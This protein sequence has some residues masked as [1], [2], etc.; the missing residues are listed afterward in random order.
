M[1]HKEELPFHRYSET[2]KYVNILNG[3]PVLSIDPDFP[4]VI[5]QFSMMHN[6]AQAESPHRHDYYEIL[7]VEEGAGQ[8][9]IDYEPYDI[10]PPVFYFLSKG[11]IHFWN[12]S[13]PL[14]GK[15][16]L[17]PREFLL[18]P[19]LGF[20][21]EGDISIFNSLSKAPYVCVDGERY[22][23]LRA[24][25]QEVSE[26]YNRGMHRNLSVLRSFVHILLVNLLRIH[27]T[28]QPKDILDQPNT[29]V[30]K[31]RQLVCENFVMIR[32]VQEYADLIGISTTHLRDTVKE[33]TGYSPGQIIRQEIIYEA[34]RM[35]ANT[36]A[37]TAEIGYALNFEDTSY[38]SRFFKRETGLS[39]T[40][41]RKVIRNKYQI[42]F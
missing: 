33:V 30:R 23:K 10:K 36:I 12:L 15:V 13:K 28:N 42:H 9:I 18:P 34:K 24:L 38:F 6:R 26:E 3:H 39:P 2:H 32:S 21:Q 17:F 8:H 41:Y 5:T 25:F 16:L 40:D 27:A 37:T 29:M 22:R 31:F 7:F 14:K 35:L 1:H 20:N 4:F 11:Q 19:A